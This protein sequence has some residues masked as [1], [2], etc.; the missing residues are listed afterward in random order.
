MI[1]GARIC[2]YVGEVLGW[3]GGKSRRGW[4][5]RGKISTNHG[6]GSIYIRSTTH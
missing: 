1:L 4:N 2:C 3:M 6:M 5:K